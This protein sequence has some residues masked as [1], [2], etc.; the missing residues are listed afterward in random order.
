MHHCASLAL[1]LS[2]PAHRG[3]HEK[4]FSLAFSDIATSER[5]QSNA[6]KSSCSNR[7]CLSFLL[8]ATCLCWV[9][10]SAGLTLPGG[11]SSV[12]NFRTSYAAAEA[13]YRHTS[14]PIILLP[15]TVL[16]PSS[17]GT[18][19]CCHLGAELEYDVLLTTTESEQGAIGSST[20]S[21]KLYTGCCRRIRSLTIPCRASYHLFLSKCCLFCEPAVACIIL[22][23][24][25]RP[26]FN[27]AGR[28][29]PPSRARC[30][31]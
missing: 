21:L 6:C 22:L 16:D 17:S 2:S 11:H 20:S 1:A 29:S 31:S 12:Q 24:R 15:I 13:D 30:T 3:L 9:Q 19:R 26:W 25:K 28:C 4:V 5:G 8:V 14:A 27:N 7:S 23:N 10:R 18:A